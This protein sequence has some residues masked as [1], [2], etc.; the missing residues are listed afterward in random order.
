MT[1]EKT[2]GA[3]YICFSLVTTRTA[4]ELWAGG[5]GNDVKVADPEQSF[6]TTDRELVWLA[7]AQHAMIQDIEQSYFFPQM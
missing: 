4:A 2:R 5:L 7:H 1:A 6:Q 3:T